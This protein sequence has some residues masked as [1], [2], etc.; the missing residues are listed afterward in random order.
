MDVFKVD[1]QF[2][3]MQVERLREVRR[4]RD[5][6]KVQASLEKVR[7]VMETG[8]N[9]MPH[10]IEAAESYCTVGEMNAVLENMGGV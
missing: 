7:N 10:L 3:K 6:G 1:P 5:N 2:E 9:V 4:R 8:E